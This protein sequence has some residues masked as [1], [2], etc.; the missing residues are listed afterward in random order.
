MNTRL[1]SADISAF[2]EFTLSMRVPCRVLRIYDCDTWTIGFE[3]N[4][5]LYYK[6]AR[7]IGVD[8]P[9]IKSTNSAEA[10]MA[11]AGR[12]CAR[13]LWLGK[14]MTADMRG[15]DK[16]GR[17]LVHLYPNTSNMTANQPS[18]CNGGGVDAAQLESVADKM[19]SL[20]IVRRYGDAIGGAGRL[21]L[22]KERWTPAELEAGIA[23]ASTYL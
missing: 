10:A 4:N 14:V 12:D 22:K 23:G 2:Q 1:A 21:N 16:Y 11:R 20:R 15:M 17:V 3:L 6:S 9:E 7:L 13:K 5:I 8:S 18:A 19:L